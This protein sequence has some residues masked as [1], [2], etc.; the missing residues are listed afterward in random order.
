MTQKCQKM[1]TKGKKNMNEEIKRSMEDF[2]MDLTRERI[3]VNIN[4]WEI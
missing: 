3:Y 2:D 4:E 1:V